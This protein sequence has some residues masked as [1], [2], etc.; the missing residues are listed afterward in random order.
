MWYQIIAYLRAQEKS[1]AIT[2]PD[3]VALIWTGLV[4]AVDLTNE[5]TTSIT[6]SILKEVKVLGS[7]IVNVL[8]SDA[9]AGVGDCS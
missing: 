8:V 1:K 7:E 2:E 6:N 5:D 9:V 3:F 4:S